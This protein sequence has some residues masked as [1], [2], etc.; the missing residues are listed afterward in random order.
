MLLLDADNELVGG[1]WLRRLAEAIVVAPDMVSD[2]C[3]SMPG[4]RRSHP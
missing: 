3:L 1:D 4:T 2:D